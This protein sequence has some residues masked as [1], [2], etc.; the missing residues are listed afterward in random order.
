MIYKYIL[1]YFFFWGGG[2]TTRNLVDYILNLVEQVGTQKR[3]PFQ[4]MF[5]LYSLLQIHNAAKHYLCLGCNLLFCLE[6]IQYNAVY[7]SN[8]L[9]TK[10]YF[11]HWELL[12]P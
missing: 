9:D 11:S 5:H 10:E 6:S 2:A 8:W 1:K 3:N 4:N 7:Y 12:P